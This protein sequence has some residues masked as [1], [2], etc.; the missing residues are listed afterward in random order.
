MLKHNQKKI[1]GTI[2]ASITFLY[3][4]IVFARFRFF[5]EHSAISGLMVFVGGLSVLLASLNLK[6]KYIYAYV[7]IFF[8]LLSFL[9]SALFVSNYDRLIHGMIFITINAGVALLLVSGYAYSRAIG[10]L[11]YGAILY[12]LYFILMGVSARDIPSHNSYNSISMLLMIACVTHYAINY[13]KFGRISIFPAFLTFIV[14]VWAIGRS[15]ILASFVLLLGIYFIKYANKRNLFYVAFS[16]IF[17]L[18]FFLDNFVS[19]INL[20]TIFTDSFLTAASRF[21]SDEE[22]LFIW[23]NYLN[24]LNGYRLF[25]GS[26]TFEDPWPEGPVL[27][28]NYHNSFIHLHARTG[29]MGLL[30]VALT[31]KVLIR[32]W[33]SNRFYFVLFF[34]L[35]LRVSTD[36]VLFFES[37]DFI[38]YY[39]IFLYVCTFRNE[40]GRIY[41]HINTKS[42]D[43]S[44]TSF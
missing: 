24:N 11:F 42:I 19:Y 31:I 1:Y 8:L 35:I 6:Y 39:F 26:N 16:L 32:F 23:S 17:T 13:M 5:P 43:N 10:V 12:F 21:D 36:W 18:F 22:R 33:K 29:M 25:F 2:A 37:F 38:F 15:G 4:L 28:F 40:S 27:G 41:F 14:C 20:E 3:I 44:Q 34:A 30:L 9:L 7:F